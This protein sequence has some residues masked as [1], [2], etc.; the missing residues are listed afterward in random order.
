MACSIK[1]YARWVYTKR[2]EHSTHHQHCQQLFINAVCSYILI[3]TLLMPLLKLE[4][5][6]DDGISRN[7]L[8]PIRM[9]GRR[10]WESELRSGLWCNNK[11]ERRSRWDTTKGYGSRRIYTVTVLLLQRA[12]W[13]QVVD[14]SIVSCAVIFLVTFKSWPAGHACSLRSLFEEPSVKCNCYLIVMHIRLLMVYSNYSDT[15][16]Y[17]VKCFLPRNASLYISCHGILLFI[18]RVSQN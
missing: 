12:G 16:L 2:D 7:S 11:L 17:I 5:P 9:D 8:N 3:L 14:S 1:M 15:L 18:Y 10:C 4:Y 13:H 6:E